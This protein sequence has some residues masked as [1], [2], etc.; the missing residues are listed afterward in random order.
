MM[1]ITPEEED[2]YKKVAN[3]LWDIPGVTG[4]TWRSD[5]IHNVGEGGFWFGQPP[6]Y[7]G[8]QGYYAI[9]VDQNRIQI[10]GNPD[11]PKEIKEHF[12]NKFPQSTYTQQS[13]THIFDGINFWF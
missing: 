12:K 3:M 13:S 1:P 6:N 8:R 7:L 4:T 2:L 5:G 9:A 10:K 11:I